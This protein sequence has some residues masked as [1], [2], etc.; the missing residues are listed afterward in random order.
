MPTLSGS[1]SVFLALEPCDMRKSFDGLHALVVSH[2]GEDPRVGAVFAFTNK[3]RTLIKLLHW[4]GTGL[5]IHAKRLEKGTFF[6]A[7]SSGEGQVKIKLAPEVLASASPPNHSR[8]SP[9]YTLS[10]RSSGKPVPDRNNVPLSGN[11]T[12]SLSSKA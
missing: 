9:G 1:L 3:T 5:W 11:A 2:L 4:D 6:W 7:K 8:P 10:K 12:A